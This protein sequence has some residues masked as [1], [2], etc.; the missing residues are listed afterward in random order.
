LIQ[1]NT[2]LSVIAADQ[3]MPA[4]WSATP[5]AKDLIIL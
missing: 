4:T 2:A 5:I 3:F 1:A